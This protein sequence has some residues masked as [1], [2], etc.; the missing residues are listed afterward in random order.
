M[1][2]VSGV[3][4]GTE[5]ARTKRARTTYTLHRENF[6]RGSDIE[7]LDKRSLSHERESTIAVKQCVL[8]ALSAP[9]ESCYIRC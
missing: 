9:L 7:P 2:Q 6:Q 3:H 1:N 8:R 5:H 4:K